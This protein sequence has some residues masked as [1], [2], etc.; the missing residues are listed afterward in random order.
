MLVCAHHA[1][2]ATLIW[3][4]FFC[5]RFYCRFRHRYYNIYALDDILLDESFFAA[6][7]DETGNKL[8]LSKGMC[9]GSLVA[10][11]SLF[12]SPS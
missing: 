4:L 8:T 2:K 1:R 7:T 5:R 10:S 12:C 3:F 9:T 6:I 11:S